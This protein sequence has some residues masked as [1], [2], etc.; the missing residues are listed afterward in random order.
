LYDVFFPSARRD[1]FRFYLPLVMT[2][3]PHRNERCRG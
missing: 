1:D 2:A 3:A